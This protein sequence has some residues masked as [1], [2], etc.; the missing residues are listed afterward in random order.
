MGGR[1]GEGRRC[2]GQSPHMRKPIVIVGCLSQRSLGEDG[3]P[4]IWLSS[5]WKTSILN[6][7]TGWVL[8]CFYPEEGEHSGI[9]LDGTFLV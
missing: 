4:P 7:L 6:N 9:A 2:L 3:R 8:G 5:F 1:M